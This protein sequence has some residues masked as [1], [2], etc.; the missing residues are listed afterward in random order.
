M[1]VTQQ[2]SLKM[3]TRSRH[4]LAHDAAQPDQD[5]HGFVIRIGRPDEGQLSGPIEADEHGGVATVCLHPIARLPRNQRWRRHVA[6]MAQAGELAID[7]ITARAGL[8][9]KRQRLA[10][11]L[12]TIA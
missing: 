6:P 4:H 10:G 5:A 7:A 3:L 9:A 2:K 11:T 1:P 8:I 12:Q